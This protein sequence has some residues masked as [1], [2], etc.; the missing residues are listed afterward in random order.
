MH[1]S[2]NSTSLP[3]YT[4]N[5]L[6]FHS[7][8]FHPCYFLPYWPIFPT[9]MH[10]SLTPRPRQVTY[11][12]FSFPLSRFHSCYL[13][14]R[15]PFPLFQRP[16]LRLHHFRGGLLHL[17]HWQCSDFC[18]R[19]F[20]YQFH[21]NKLYTLTAFSLPRLWAKWQTRRPSMYNVLQPTRYVTFCNSLL[22][23][24]QS[25]YICCTS[26]CLYADNRRYVLFTA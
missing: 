5:S 3:T 18:E 2:F 11:S 26:V 24:V 15:F 9:H 20:L 13:V 25:A 1:L 12:T 14:P 4:L 22:T 8:V 7:R 21:I 10:L 19:D 6:V 16:Q 17:Q 23:V